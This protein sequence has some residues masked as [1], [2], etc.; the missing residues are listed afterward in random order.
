MKKECKDAP[1]EQRGLLSSEMEKTMPSKDGWKEARRRRLLVSHL[2]FDSISFGALVSLTLVVT[3]RWREIVAHKSLRVAR[4]NAPTATSRQHVI[5][6]VADDLGYNDVGWASSD[7]GLCTPRIDA[8]RSAGIELAMLYGSSTCTPSRAS[9]LTARYAFKLGVQHHQLDAAEPWGLGPDDEVALP[10]VFKDNGYRTALVGKWHLGHYRAE[11]LPTRRGFDDFVGFYAGG[12]NYYS[13]VAV[14][15]AGRADD[16]FFD[17]SRGD[18]PESAVTTRHVHSTIELAAAAEDVVRASDRR[19][20]FLVLALPNPHAPLNVPP[21]AYRAHD[22]CV[23]SIQN[24]D[25]RAF[26]ALTALWDDAI[27]NVSRTAR[28]A[29]GSNVLWLVVSDNG[30]DPEQGGS[31]VPLRG[32]KRYLFDGGVRLRALFY[33]DALRWSKRVYPGLTHL[34]DLAATLASAAS[35]ETRDRLEG[36]DG[37]DHWHAILDEGDAW[38]YA[39]SNE[40]SFSDRRYPRSELVLTVDYLDDSL[41]YLGFL[42]SAIVR[43]DPDDGCLKALFNV[44]DVKWYSPPTDPATK[45]ALLPDDFRFSALFN[46]SADPHENTDLKTTLPDLFMALHTKL[47]TVYLPQMRRARNRPADPNAFESWRTYRHSF[48]GPW[49]TDEPPAPCLDP[50]YRANRG[51]FEI[52]TGLLSNCTTAPVWG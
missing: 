5:L 44:E 10:E 16:C 15:R 13:R 25:R 11:T 3:Y 50:D 14:C 45:V 36:T 18:E 17:F 19:P 46:L 22:A 27:G 26:A 47:E 41:E 33:S 28:A 9:L 24:E 48:L 2:I 32:A 42:R 30:G 1:E 31:N 7:M 43:C 23:S 51:A 35:L 29:L 52:R 39:S 8:M 12:E 38:A 49:R 20:L 37:F 6:A 4:A 21:E 34:V 40:S